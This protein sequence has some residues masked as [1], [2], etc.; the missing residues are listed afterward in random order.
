M[1][2]REDKFLPVSREDMTRR[3]W[4][5][6]DFLLVSGD[7]YVDHPSFACAVIGRVLE[8]H[9]Y[10]VGLI[11]Q[12]DWRSTADFK[13]LGKPRLGVLITAGNLDSMLN[14]YTA[15]KKTRHNDAYAPGGKAGLRPDRATIV[16]GARIRE[17]WKNIP[18][19]IGGVEASLR[20]WTHYDYWSDT[21]RRPIL[22]DSWADLLIYG[23]GEKAVVEVA[24]NLAGGI[25]VNDITYVR[26]TMVKQTAEQV[27]VDKSTVIV[28]SWEAINA[29]KRFF[30]EAFRLQ[31]EQQDPF[32][33]KKVAQEIEGRGFVVQNPPVMPLTEAEMD[34]IYDL[35]YQRTWHPMY[36]AVGGVP[37]IEEVRFSIVSHRGCFGSCSF[38]AIHSH[39]GRIIQA[40]SHKSI[41]HE[42][43]LITQM[44]DFKGYIHDVGGPTANFRH[45]ACKKQL[46]VG[47]CV[48]RQCLS[49]KPC[50]AIDADHSDYLSLLRQI[51]K[52]PGVKKVFIRSGIRYD[53]L[54][55]DKK[56]DFMRELCQHH[57]SGQLKVAPEHVSD[58]V[59]RLMGKPGRATYDRFR[60][61]FAS[62][63][64]QLSKEQYL[65]PY[66]ISS[67]PGSSLNDAVILAEY[68]RDIGH[69]PEQ[70]QDFIPTPGSLSTAMYY[71]EIDP[72]TGQRLFVAKNLHD[73]AMQRALLQYRNPRNYALVREALQK[74]GRADLIG[75]GAKCLVPAENKTGYRKN[76]NQGAQ[77]HGDK[78]RRSFSAS[79]DL[80]KETSGRQP[81][82]ATEQNRRQ[83]RR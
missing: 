42:A 44:P 83:K 15:A 9:G 18:I 39:Q 59:L 64:C 52:L 8:S 40:R 53:Y 61:A 7:A 6:L 19:I 31:A 76:D 71:S 65:V 27:A 70:V 29:Q 22:F 2:R 1:D 73:K 80:P 75:N 48:D 20:R 35:P 60:E 26:G 57:V 12:P 68:L 46:K 30:A 56:P 32:Y 49:P 13:R 25:P 43:T 4:D 54:L 11:C 41:L 51:R 74:A 3:G 63:N 33:G 62:M 37:A 55:Q 50:A 58:K 78:K 67:H 23:M 82:K 38:C 45:P 36:D 16:Y 81:Q 14:K 17:L 5:Q 47:A 10:K 77:W 79:H 66:F 28:P 72:Y 34:A 69:S 21:L 24:D